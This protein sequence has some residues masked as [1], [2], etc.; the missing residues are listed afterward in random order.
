V[1]VA[2]IERRGERLVY[3]RR[4]VSL[5]KVDLVAVALKERTNI[6]V[7]VASEDSWAA[8]LV[9]VQVEDREYRAVARGIEE[10]GPLPRTGERSGFRL[11]VAHDRRDDQV[12]IVKCG[13]ERV[14]Q[15]V[16]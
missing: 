5:H 10:T 3:P 9:P 16:A 4:V 8:D 12:R 14:G 11:A 7:G 1:V 15:H 13:A 6:V 2:P